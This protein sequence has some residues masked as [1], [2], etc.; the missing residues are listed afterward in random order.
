MKFLA[1][2]ILAISMAGTAAAQQGRKSAEVSL[3]ERTPY[4]RV[5]I[6]V[7]PSA[8]RIKVLHFSD[9]DGDSAM[10]TVVVSD[11][12]E[13]VTY[14]SDQASVYFANVAI[15]GGIKHVFDGPTVGMLMDPSQTTQNA[16]LV[17]PLKNRSSDAQ[18]IREVF[19][20]QIRVT[21]AALNSK[22]ETFS[23]SLS[24][25]EYRALL[26]IK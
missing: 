17:V 1:I 9:Q 15:I 14:N 10:D 24:E 22:T 20:L 3:V 16:P 19:R 8:G 2:M 5:E 4:L 12:T 18:I 7:R 11:R 26:Y 13:D 21:P 6:T 25:D 23:V